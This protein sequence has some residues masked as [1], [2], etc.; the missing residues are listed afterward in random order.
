M[1]SML[2]FLVE[3]K[4]RKFDGYYIIFLLILLLPVYIYCYIYIVYVCLRDGCA[5]SGQ[6]QETAKL[7]LCHPLSHH[8]YVQLLNAKWEVQRGAYII[9]S[10]YNIAGL[11]GWPGCLWC[12][13]GARSSI[14]DTLSIRLLMPDVLSLSFWKENNKLP[15]T[16]TDGPAV[17][18][19]AAHQQQ[20]NNKRKEIKKISGPDDMLGCAISS[21]NT[22]WECCCWTVAI[23]YLKTFIC[24]HR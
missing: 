19:A 8:I 5:G 12:W 1:S 3:E 11:A 17:A 10:Y 6:Y 20:W 16:R 18:V 15:S 4:Q 24:A 9:C 2:Y 14:Y 13:A 21:G 7:Y 23:F 22:K